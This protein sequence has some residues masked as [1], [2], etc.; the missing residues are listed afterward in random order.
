MMVVFLHCLPPSDYEVLGLDAIFRL[1]IVFVT[2]PCVPIFFMITGILILPTSCE[3]ES[4][5]SFYKKRISK[6]LYPLIFWGIVY[7]VVPYMLNLQEL[8]DTIKDLILV[9]FV[10]PP[11]IGA[12]LW[13]LYILIGIYLIIPFISSKVYNYANYQK[14]YL[15][16]WLLSSLVFLWQMYEPR[17]LGIN[18][19]EHNVH[20]LS[21]FWGYFGFCILG[22]YINKSIY[23]MKAMKAIILYIL[24]CLLMFLG[25]KY[26]DSNLSQ[27]ISSF[28]SIPSIILTVIL[29]MYIKSLRINENGFIY[30][31]IK[32]VIAVH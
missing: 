29:F 15:I 4:L 27:W 31:L 12:V 20:S 5:N 1:G 8:T 22:L 26:G 28:L 10:Y 16:I 24:V 17:V 9:P 18:E 21:Y 30:K 11:E 13:Y 25:N 3:I 7:S 32:K 6:V 2:S 19:W 14:I 23:K